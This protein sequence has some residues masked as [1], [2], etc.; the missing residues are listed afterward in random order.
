MNLVTA[1]VAAA[2]LGLASTFHCAAMC[3]PLVGASC[4]K[5]GRL[6]ASRSGAYAGARALGYGVVGGIAGAL[7]APLAGS[8]QAPV[9][10]LAAAAAAFVIA[11]A[12]VRL[13]RGRR[14]QSA[15]ELVQLGR[16]APPRR[17]FPPAL[18]G[19]VT[20]VF[21]CGALIGALVLASATG[22]AVAGASAMITFAITSLPGLLVAVV[23]AASL[24]G[25]LGRLRR[26]TGALLIVLAGVTVAEAAM[27]LRPKGHACCQKS[28]VLSRQSS[29][30]SGPHH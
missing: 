8:W 21:P 22:S 2:G 7:G 20:S 18:L 19:L 26:F 24:A 3:G 5:D 16:K 17:A 14:G 6:D 12:G 10:V 15:P 27:T 30:E 11:R 25:R 28:S 23:G 4:S 1:I 13:V 29:A 9:R